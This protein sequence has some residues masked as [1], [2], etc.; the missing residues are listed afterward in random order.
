M[1]RIVVKVNKKGIDLLQTDDFNWFL[2]NSNDQSIEYLKGKKA[3]DTERNLEVFE[4][5]RKGGVVSD[6]KLFEGIS[7]MIGS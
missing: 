5:I 2:D 7:R 3:Y 6:G 4:L 1:Q